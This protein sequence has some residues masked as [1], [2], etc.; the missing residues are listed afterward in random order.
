MAAVAIPEPDYSK[1][2]AGASY[3]I[4]L[5]GIP[6]DWI[7]APLTPTLSPRG[8]GV[9]GGLF[10]RPFLPSGRRTALQGGYRAV[11]GNLAK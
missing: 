11:F 6:V 5:V 7:K 8:E 10:G 9:C 3:R 4:W 2:A 1:A